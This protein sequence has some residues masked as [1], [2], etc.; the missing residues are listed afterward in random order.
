MRPIDADALTE[1]SWDADT[2]CGYVQVVDVGDIEDAPTIDAVPVIR[3]GECKNY[4]EETAWCEI[5]SCFVNSN[6]EFC[7]P[8]ESNEWKMFDG[9]YYCADGKRRDEA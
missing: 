1:K 6:G 4:D 2:R 8:W 3:C 7:N 5:H 9:A